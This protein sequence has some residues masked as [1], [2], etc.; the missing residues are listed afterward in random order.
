MCESCNHTPASEGVRFIHPDTGVSR[1]V[2]VCVACVPWTDVNQYGEL[3][4]LERQTRIT[5]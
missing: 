2:R 1:S 3:V 4:V 5:A